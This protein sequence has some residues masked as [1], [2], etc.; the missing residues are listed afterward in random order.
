VTPAQLLDA[1][2][3]GLLDYDAH[4]YP[5][6]GLN[7]IAQREVLLPQYR[8]KAQRFLMPRLWEAM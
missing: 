8:D 6:T 3:H 7:D 4:H 1:L 5:G 2:A